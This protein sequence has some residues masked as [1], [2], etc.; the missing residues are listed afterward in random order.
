MSEDESVKSVRCKRAAVIAAFF[1]VHIVAAHMVAGQ[2]LAAPTAAN[3]QVIGNESNLPLAPELIP[4]TALA[5]TPAA[6]A[7]M[8]AQ[9]L[10]PGSAALAKPAPSAASP[11]APPHAVCAAP[12]DLTHFDRPL[13]HTMRRLAGGMPLI[14][15]AIGSSSTAG[16]QASS[17]AATY[18]ARL[19]VELRARFPGHDITVLNRGVNGE[20]TDEMMARFAT[21]VI[22]AHPQLV[23]WQ[24]GTNSVL[25]DK[26]LQAHSSQL[27]HGLDELKTA[28]VDVVLIDPQYAPKVLAKSETPAMV[29]QIALAAKKENVDL[30]R[31][32]A[33]MRDWHEVRH[34]GFD[35]FVAPD[36]LHM[37]DWGYACWA[38]LIGKAIAE[39]AT[40]P[41]AS[42]AAHPVRPADQP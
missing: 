24:V 1:A 28:G 30:F 15:V 8:A 18:P 35:V 32:F 21:D 26:P 40:R 36:A 25:R 10:H 37:N 5:A 11:L 22:A 14:I 33:V 23:L 27:R 9:S 34:L 31:R 2:I 29:E 38:K 19:A 6:T 4:L 16:A 41:I 17:P 7:A 39:A 12:A 13:I 20:V 42:A 3:A